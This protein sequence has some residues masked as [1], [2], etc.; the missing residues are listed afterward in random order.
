LAISSNLYQFVHHEKSFLRQNS[1]QCPGNTLV[2]AQHTARK[3]I[4]PTFEREECTKH[5]AN[6]VISE[7]E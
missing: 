1:V 6:H 5:G 4:L 3:D 7:T 2:S